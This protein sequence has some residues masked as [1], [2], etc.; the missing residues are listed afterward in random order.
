MCYWLGCPHVEELGDQCVRY[1][2]KLGWSDLEIKLFTLSMLCQ[3]V[4]GPQFQKFIF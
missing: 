2:Y 4:V 1:T 3:L